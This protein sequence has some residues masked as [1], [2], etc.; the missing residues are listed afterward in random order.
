MIVAV[1]GQNSGKSES[2]E[3]L[4]NTQLSFIQL[5]GG[6]AIGVYAEQKKSYTLLDS[7]Q[8]AVLEGTSTAVRMTTFVCSRLSNGIT[9]A[10]MECW[11]CS[12]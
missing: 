12:L 1:S 11:E 4:N 5:G 9:P 8:M 6:I 2:F 7:P 3:I 10:D